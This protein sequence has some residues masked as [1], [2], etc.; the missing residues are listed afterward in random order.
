MRRFHRSL[1][2]F[3]KRYNVYL[4]YRTETITTKKRNDEENGSSDTFHITAKN[5]TSERMVE[6]ESDQ[7]SGSSW[8]S[9]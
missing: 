2:V 1:Q 3:S 4:G 8:E 9:A 7:L 6:L 5:D